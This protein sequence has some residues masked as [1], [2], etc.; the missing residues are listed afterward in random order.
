MSKRDMPYDQWHS[1]L[2]LKLDNISIKYQKRFHAYGLLTY[3]PII[4]LPTL[5]AAQAICQRMVR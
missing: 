4:Y 1:N 2:K 3:S 5:S